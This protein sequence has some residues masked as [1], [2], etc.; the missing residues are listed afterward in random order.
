LLHR[1]FFAAHFITAADLALYT[2]LYSY[3]VWFLLFL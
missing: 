1:V 3:V 2:N